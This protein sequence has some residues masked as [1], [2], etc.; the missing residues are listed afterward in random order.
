MDLRICSPQLGISPASNLGGA[1][2]DREILKGLARLGAEIE[3]PL[4]R[5]ECYE[6]IEG[7]HIHLT[8]R[9]I[10]YTYEY[11]WLFLPSLLRLWRSQRFDLLRVHSPTLAPLARLFKSVTGVPAVGNYHHWEFNRIIHTINRAVIRSYALITTVSHFSARQFASKYRLAQEQIVVIYNGV[12]DKYQPCPRKKSLQRALG[13][14]GKVVLLYLGVL[15]H[16]KNLHFL[17]DVLNLSLRHQADLMLVIAGAGPQEDEL[18]AYARRLGV[19]R[20]IIFTGYVPEEDKVDYYNLADVF[21]FPSLLEGFGMAAAEAMACGVPVVCSD[22]SSLPEV[23]GDAGLLCSPTDAE[24][25]SAQI[26]RLA[27]DPALRRE[28]GEAGRKRVR[29][30]FSWERAARLTYECYR[31]AVQS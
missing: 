9:H 8:S 4:P 1:V 19:E 16:R 12:D 5:G 22:T 15:T 10:R 18:R 11:N 17:L 14:E 29:E 7:W 3:I 23:V 25:F 2:H 30:T 21:V 24:A 31:R 6:N 20:S 26:V 27:K 13:L 28:L